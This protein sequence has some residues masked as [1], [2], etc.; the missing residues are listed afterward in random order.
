MATSAITPQW[1]VNDIAREFR[2]R[3]VLI[4]GAGHLGWHP[5]DELYSLDDEPAP[6]PP[7]TTD[8]DPGRV[9]RCKHVKRGD[10]GIVD[11]CGWQGPRVER[12][13][14]CNSN[15]YSNRHSTLITR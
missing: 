7:A 1:V 8:D 15:L 14:V 10:G 12:C 11:G 4:D 6:Q 3:T 9:Y 5:I 13:P 2:N